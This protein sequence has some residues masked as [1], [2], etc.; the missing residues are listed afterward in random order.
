VRRRNDQCSDC[1]F[2]ALVVV[3]AARVSGRNRKQAGL[4]VAETGDWH[5]WTGF[6]SVKSNMSV[7]SNIAT[8]FAAQPHGLNRHFVTDAT[9]DSV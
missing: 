3:V 9:D 5:W 6:L 4:R 2:A 1:G 8:G 7:E